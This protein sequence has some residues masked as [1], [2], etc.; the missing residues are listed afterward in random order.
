MLRRALKSVRKFARRVTRRI[1]K[2]VAKVVRK[3]VIGIRERLY[4]PDFID[5]VMDLALVTAELLFPKLRRAR[6]IREISRTLL[7][8]VRSIRG[9][10]AAADM[11]DTG[12]P[13]AH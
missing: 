3:V 2:T 9:D 6:P 1:A 13:L 4:E 10:W 8:T 12:W 5:E 7:R 11:S